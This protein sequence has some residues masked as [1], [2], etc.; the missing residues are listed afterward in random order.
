MFSGCAYVSD[1]CFGFYVLGYACVSALCFELGFC[2]KHGFQ[3]GYADFSAFFFC[4]S[5]LV[6][7]GTAGLCSDFYG[8][9]G[10]CGCVLVVE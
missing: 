3:F 8:F 1:L 10:G 4:S 2:F 7:M 9:D 6:L 5:S